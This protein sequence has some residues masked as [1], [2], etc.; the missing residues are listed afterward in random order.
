M[1]ACLGAGG[2]ASPTL[3]LYVAPGGNDGWSGALRSVNRSKTDGPLATLEGALEKSR[4][5]RRQTPGAQVR[6]LL[7]GGVYSLERPLV[8]APE[9]SD[10]AVEAFRQE[11]PV[12]TSEARLRGWRRSSVNSNVWETQPPAGWRFHALSVNGVR[13]GRARL[14]VSGFFHYVGDVVKGHPALLKVHPGDVKEA[15]ARGG[16]EL[17]ALQ[18]WGQARNQI[19][20]VDAASNTV[21]LAGAA[22]PNNRCESDGRYYIENAPDGLRPG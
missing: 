14:P 6:V 17:I 11:T 13:K 8:L 18:A 16:V 20:G 3:T 9:D 7:R 19:R 10:L 5:A 4:A 1:A 2:A 21:K 12:I 22:L 15:W